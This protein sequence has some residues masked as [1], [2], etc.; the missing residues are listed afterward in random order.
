M[1]PALKVGGNRT[2]IFKNKNYLSANNKNSVKICIK[3]T[4]T[5]A[6]CVFFHE[7]GS[8]IQML[9]SFLKKIKKIS[10]NFKKA[11][12]KSGLLYYNLSC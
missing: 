7:K 9:L 8:K 5:V 6:F 3:T 2:D 11:L 4:A 1:L 12:D 10:K